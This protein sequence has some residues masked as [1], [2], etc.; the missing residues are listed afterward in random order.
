MSAFAT[1]LYHG[2]ETSKAKDMHE[3]GTSSTSKIYGQL[4]I[5]STLSNHLNKSPSQNYVI[6]QMLRPK[7]KPWIAYAIDSRV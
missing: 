5:A 4:F 6:S 3:D 7:I 1:Y 2:L